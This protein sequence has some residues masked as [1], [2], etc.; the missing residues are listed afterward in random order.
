MKRVG[1][2]DVKNNEVTVIGFGSLNGTD[3]VYDDDL[4]VEISV[5][6]VLLDNGVN[7]IVKDSFIGDEDAILKDI[8]I[9]KEKGYKII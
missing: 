5:T 8:S 4:G 2:I 6:K 1:I 7:F 9:Y 3:T